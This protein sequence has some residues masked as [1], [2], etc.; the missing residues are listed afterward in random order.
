MNGSMLK[1]P[2]F[3]FYFVTYWLYAL[4]YIKI[5]M[6]TVIMITTIVIVVAR[7]YP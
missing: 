3:E 6:M 2:K 5:I 4:E 1:M 7:C